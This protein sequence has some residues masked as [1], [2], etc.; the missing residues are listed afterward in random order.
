MYAFFDPL[1][2]YTRNL[3]ATDNK[4]FTLL[5]LCWTPGKESPIHD[6]PCDGCWVQVLEGSAIESRY[7]KDSATDELRCT[8]TEEFKSESSVSTICVVAKRQFDALCLS[9]STNV[10]N[11]VSATVSASASCHFLFVR[12]RLGIHQ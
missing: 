6:H 1:K 8:K 9:L 12:G 2:P 5:L 7:V 4:T 11:I 10:P 3:V